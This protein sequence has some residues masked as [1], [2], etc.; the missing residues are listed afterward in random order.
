MGGWG[1]GRREIER[2]GTVCASGIG[3]WEENERRFGEWGNSHPWE[4][5]YRWHVGET[6]TDSE[7]NSVTPSCGAS[8]NAALYCRWTRWIHIIC[9][10]HGWAS[11][12]QGSSS[13]PP[14]SLGLSPVK[15]ECT[16]FYRGCSYPTF[17]VLPMWSLQVTLRQREVRGT[18]SSLTPIEDPCAI[19]LLQTFTIVISRYLQ[20]I[21]SST[22]WMLSPLYEML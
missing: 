22:P 6:V 19:W 20:G 4:S 18:E 15:P 16:F 3:F 5:R 12:G 1:K 14:L 7:G 13:C 9:Y 2:K 11:E 21:G 8:L 10:P 17:R